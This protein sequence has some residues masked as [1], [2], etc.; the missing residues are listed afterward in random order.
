MNSGD[1]A[2]IAQ[3]IW[4]ETP[5]EDAYV[6]LIED[7]D[8]SDE[9]DDRPA[10]APLR[11]EGNRTGLLRLAAELLTA[12]AS[13]GSTAGYMFHSKPSISSIYRTTTTEP[14][15]FNAAP[16]PGRLARATAITGCLTVLAIAVA[17]MIVGFFTI[18]KM[19]F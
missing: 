3:Q 2:R 14:P 16:Q 1:A 10:D 12:V 6:W 4:D 17:C 9:Y 8:H 7:N 15:K 19:I 5:K 18:L 13:G 11:L